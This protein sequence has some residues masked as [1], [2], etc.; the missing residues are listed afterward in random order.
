MLGKIEDVASLQLTLKHAHNDNVVAKRE[1][2]KILRQ[3]LH[4][5]APLPYHLFFGTWYPNPMLYP[6]PIPNPNRNPN[7]DPTPYPSRISS[8]ESD[9]AKAEAIQ[10]KL[11]RDTDNQKVSFVSCS[12]IIS[13]STL[14]NTLFFP[15]TTASV[16]KKKGVVDGKKNYGTG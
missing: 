15:I 7:L 16:G 8:I 14:T 2:K 10:A 13:T 11:D 5:P 1:A 4:F 3:R 12:T 9:N 6:N